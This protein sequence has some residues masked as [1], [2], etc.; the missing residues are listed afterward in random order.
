[1]YTNQDN[2]INF[3]SYESKVPPQCIE[4]EEAILG[5]I[6]LDPGAIARVRDEL[7]PYHFY[8]GAHSSIYQALLKLNEQE[9]PT[10]LKV[11]V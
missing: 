9:Q 8:I 5:G 4:A 1:M 10:D 2:V 3:S 6:L 7:K 11:L